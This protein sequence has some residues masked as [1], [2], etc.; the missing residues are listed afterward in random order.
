MSSLGQIVYSK[1]NVTNE[2]YQINLSKGIKGYVIVQIV[3]N[4]RKY[5]NKIII[6]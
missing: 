5:F 4:K 2:L 6:Q 1:D 3:S